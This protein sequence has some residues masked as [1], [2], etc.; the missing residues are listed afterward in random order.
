MNYSDFIHIL[1]TN[2]EFCRKD[3]CKNLL[4]MIIKQTEIA[5]TKERRDAPWYVIIANLIKMYILE[6][7]WNICVMNVLRGVN[8]KLL[9]K[10]E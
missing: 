4:T 5:Y 1:V 2:R 7:A 6:V 9:V 10:M 3:C 8:I